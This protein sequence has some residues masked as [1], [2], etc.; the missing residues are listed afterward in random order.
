[1][2]RTMFRQQTNHL[3]CCH[4]LRGSQVVGGEPGQH[5]GVCGGQG[6][7]QGRGEGGVGGGLVAVLCQS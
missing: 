2:V 1:M 5:D 6:G 7:G 4:L 3:Q